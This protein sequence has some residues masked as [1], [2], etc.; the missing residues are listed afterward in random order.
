MSPPIL[1]LLLIQRA[2]F[3]L[4]PLQ[5]EARLQCEIKATKTIVITVAVYFLCYV[6]TIIYAVV[7]SRELKQ[8]NSWFAFIASSSL[9]ISSVLNP[10]IY[11]LRSKR[12]RT[13]FKQFLKYPFGSS[14]FEGELKG[15]PRKLDLER[16]VG[17]DAHQA[18]YN[19]QRGQTHLG[20]RR[21]GIRIVPIEHLEADPCAHH[22]VGDGEKYDD[23]KEQ[24]G[25]A[26][27]SSPQARTSCQGHIEESDKDESKS[28]NCGLNNKSRKR[29]SFFNKERVFLMGVSS[30]TKTGDTDEEEPDINVRRSERET[31]SQDSSEKRTN[32]IVT[33]EEWIREVEELEQEVTSKKTE[34]EV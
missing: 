23:R 18:K 14:D 1:P 13:A 21:N 5:A 25:D 33:I 20:K 29:H 8:V 27:S 4:P 16:V 32:A 30:I 7:G 9:Y 11:Y 19:N 3:N 24:S 10:I 31:G 2:D 12:F 6:P 15:K 34:T 22:E 28:K 17:V 26:G